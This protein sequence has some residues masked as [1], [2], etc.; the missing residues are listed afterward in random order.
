MELET[1]ASIRSVIVVQ[2]I[3]LAIPVVIAVPIVVSVRIIPTYPVWTIG[4]W[5]SI[6]A[7]IAIV[8]T[9]VIRTYTEA[10]V[11]LPKSIVLTPA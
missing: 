4:V 1:V 10:V 11:I 2:V 8:V 6:S 9:T 7:I 5:I 3:T